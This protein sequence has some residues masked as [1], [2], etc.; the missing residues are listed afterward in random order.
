MVEI[1][2]LNPS[3]LI[4]SIGKFSSYKLS[5]D[6]NNLPSLVT[7]YKGVIDIS[8]LYLNKQSIASYIEQEKDIPLTAM[9]TKF[10]VKAEDPGLLFL[11]KNAERVRILV[12]SN[13]PTDVEIDLYVEGIIKTSNY[14][15][16]IKSWLKPEPLL[17]IDSYIYP[18]ELTDNSYYS[19]KNRYSI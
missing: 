16:Y 19:Y 11:C 7:L 10:V 5:V 4:Q 18:I 13:K 14:D 2:S 17:V 1:L 15:S 6:S 8:H 3:I 9:D 12:E